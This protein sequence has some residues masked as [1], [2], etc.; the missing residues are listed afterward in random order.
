MSPTFLKLQWS[1]GD[2]LSTTL[3]ATSGLPPSFFFPSLPYPNPNLASKRIE[4]SYWRQQ[5]IR[6]A[7]CLEGPEL[8]GGSWTKGTVKSTGSRSINTLCP[9][10]SYY[11]LQWPE[12]SRKW[13][14]AQGLKFLRSLSTLWY[15]VEQKGCGVSWTDSSRHW[16]QKNKQ[17][18]AHTKKAYSLFFQLWTSLIFTHISVWN[19]R[20]P[21]LPSTCWLSSLCSLL[22]F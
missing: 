20:T 5:E 22:D 7:F 15:M 1:H 2:S 6:T 8:I 17:W 3:W 14:L 19:R 21:K 16:E 11:F 4:T 18:V 13:H 12:S 9:S 10:V